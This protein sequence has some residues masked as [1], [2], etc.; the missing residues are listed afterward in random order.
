MGE[1]DNLPWGL[2]VT[3]APGRISRYD[4]ATGVLK[5]DASSVDPGPADD[6]S[7]L[8]LRLDAPSTG[9][10]LWSSGADAN[11]LTLVRPFGDLDDEAGVLSSGEP[12]GFA[13]PIGELA[14][15]RLPALQPPCLLIGPLDPSSLRTDL[16]L[17]FDQSWTRVI[18]IRAISAS[19][20]WQGSHVARGAAAEIV[21][22][23]GTDPFGLLSRYARLVAETLGVRLVAD[24]PAVSYLVAAE[25]GD[26]QRAVEAGAERLMSRF[27][28]A[29]FVAAEARYGAGGLEAAEDGHDLRPVAE[30]ILKAGYRP[31][32]RWAPLFLDEHSDAVARGWSF[33]ASRTA[34]GEVL[35]E[36]ERGQRRILDTTNPAARSW[37][38]AA[39]NKAVREWGYEL[40]E[41]HGLGE[42]ES[43]VGRGNIRA[44]IQAM[45]IAA[46]ERLIG[47]TGPPVGAAIGIADWVTAAL[48]TSSPGDLAP[49]ETS[50]AVQEFLKRSWTNGVWWRNVL[51]PRV[52]AGVARET[53]GPDRMVATALATSREVAGRDGRPETPIPL[54]PW[55]SPTPSAWVYPG[56][57]ERRLIAV[58][59]WDESPRWV[60][61]AELLEPGEVA[62]DFW[63]GRLIGKGDVELGPY[64]AA[65][66]QVTGPG[67]TP[68]CAGDSGS[69]SFD[70][71]YQRQV[72]GRLQLRNDGQSPRVVAVETRGQVFELDLAPGEMRWFD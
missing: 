43:V 51:N 22:L 31:G 19:T 65:L 35:V 1:L 34:G 49:A 64:G 53:E 26:G 32:L 69:V 38:E 28:T 36:T 72:S 54:D 7:F 5:A 23:E 62:F 37:L 63:N 29:V 39:V 11:G 10:M 4:Q 68:R 15:I 66:W 30:R 18:E 6:S 44:A 56:E 58:F 61:V 2:T 52:T 48:P 46:G 13:V 50:A 21:L 12:V 60:V 20:N 45:R 67:P 9:G 33:P 24:L 71:L 41:L 16:E 17:T 40:I 57:G 42:A 27:G 14:V 8:R 47:V 25:D 70:R 59:N 3:S 55:E